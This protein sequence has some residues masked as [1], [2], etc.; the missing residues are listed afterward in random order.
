MK[1]LSLLLGAVLLCGVIFTI[2]NQAQIHDWPK[3]AILGGSVALL[4]VLA[5]TT[6][7]QILAGK[8]NIYST[9]QQWFFRAIFY[10]IAIVCVLL[11][12]LF[13]SA[14]LLK[15]ENHETPGVIEFLWNAT[16]DLLQNPQKPFSIANFIHPAAQRFVLMFVALILLISF[17]SIL[18]SR[19]EVRWQEERHKRA[20]EQAELTALRA[21]MDPHFL[22]NA[23]NTI[24]SR[25]KSEPEKAEKLLIQLSDLMRY[26]FQNS[27]VQQVPL[28]EEIRFNK[29]YLDLL[30]ARFPDN[31]HVNWKLE[32]KDDSVPTPAFLLQPII[33]NAVRHGW[34]DQSVP[35]NLDVEVKT[36]SGHIALKVIDD[37]Q[38]IPS[39]MQD[40]I[41]K[42]D[43]AL[44][45]L[46]ERLKLIYNKNA[47]LKFNSKWGG[48]ATVDIGVP[49]KK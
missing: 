9:G 10:A 32:A 46:K 17:A 48:G 1:K 35:L 25:L 15:A 28:R 49:I 2:Y 27:G 23:L 30:Q 16:V 6:V 12:G 3:A 18:G 29:L 40:K 14:N 42:S 24:I 47:Y 21:Q 38:G 41:F 37:G 39:A 20:R 45:N 34:Q 26:I 7:H 43:H 31:L 4:L 19:I 36:G 22:F 5:I 11:I 8:L 13:I 44:A 33:E